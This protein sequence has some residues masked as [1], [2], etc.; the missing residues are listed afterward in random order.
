MSDSRPSV[1]EL[2]TATKNVIALGDLTDEE[3]KAVDDAME[4]LAASIPEA[5][6]Q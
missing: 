3:A 1:E 2:I 5:S 6:E 4:H